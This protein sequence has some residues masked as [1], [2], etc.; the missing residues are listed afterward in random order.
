MSVNSLEAAPSMRYTLTPGSALLG[1]L[2]V[3]GD[4][5]ISH[6]AM[7]FASLASGESVI[8][9]FLEGE[10]TRATALA[11]SH[12]GVKM[13]VP[14]LGERIVYGKGLHGLSESHSNL[15]MGNAGTAMRLMAGLLCGQNFDSVLVGDASLSNRPM[16]RV[17]EPLTQMGAN[18][19]SHEGGFAP[20]K[21]ARVKKLQGINFATKVASA[22]IKSAIL[23]AGLYADGITTV[24]EPHPTRDYTESMMMAFGVPIEVHQAGHVSV[25]RAHHLRA[26]QIKIPADFS[27]AAFWIVA[28]SIIPNS[29][30]L[31]RGVGINER[32]TGL[33]R[34]LQLM[35]GKI[36]LHNRH[37]V[38]GEWV[39]DIRVQSAKLKGIVVP[40]TWVP[41]MIDEC[42]ILFVA[43]AFAEGQTVL[44]GASELR[45]KESDRITVMSRALINAGINVIEH[46]DGASIEGGQF[47]PKVA[48][49]SN[50]DHRCAMSL[51]LAGWASENQVQ[52]LDCANIATSYPEFV[53]HVHSLGAKISVS[54]DD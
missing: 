47:R 42:P 51:L 39:A 11:M 28:A 38:S 45:V 15:D 48:L 21:I 17:I 7:M 4:K 3:P 37:F 16:A 2:Q 30:L 6:R 1:E 9:G 44:K 33:L 23:L 31:L 13:V 36:E 12:L 53:E 10:D 32:R 24:R 52:V 40:E 34:V 35:G 22:Q 46:A 25:Q 5:S 26:Q 8:S 54:S 27:S 41:D 19:Q 14:K 18:I 49:H 20:L 50:G 43:A 29:D